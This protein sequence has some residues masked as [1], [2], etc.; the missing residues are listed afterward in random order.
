MLDRA[1]GS[2]I[3][4]VRH[5]LPLQNTN[6]P[7]NRWPLHPGGHGEIVALRESGTLPRAGSWFSSPEPKAL[8]TA[9]L[10]TAAPITVVAGLSEMARPA[11]WYEDFD[12]LVAQG[13]ATPDRPAA[14]GWET[15]ASTLRRVARA[16]NQIATTH[17]EDVLIL[18]GHGTAWT[19]A[20]AALTGAAPDAMAWKRL[21]FPD[22]V[23]IADRKVVS[24]WGA[25][26]KG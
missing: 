11:A 26:A 6:L 20:V 23:M 4:L 14:P 9:Q 24:A 2:V 8:E 25:W 22:Y 10:L 19:L 1:S 13:L 12:S 16:I 15:A 21:L 7:A 18:V 3:H 5:G 17:E